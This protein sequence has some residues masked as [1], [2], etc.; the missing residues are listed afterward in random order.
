MIRKNMM[1]YKLKAVL[2]DLDI[3]FWGSGGST[4]EEPKPSAKLGHLRDPKLSE[5]YT[6]IQVDLF[7]KISSCS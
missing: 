1:L 6:S 5:N 2:S 3:V 4:A 7:V